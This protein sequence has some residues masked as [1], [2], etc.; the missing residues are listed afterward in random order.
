VSKY[1]EQYERM[2]RLYDRFKENSFRLPAEVSSGQSLKDDGLVFFLF[3]LH[4]RD[5]IVNDDELP[6]TVRDAA[7]PYVK[8]SRVL[9]LCHD[10][11]IGAKH[12]TVRSPL[13]PGE[14][15]RLNPIRTIEPRSAEM[16][17]GDDDDD[18]SLPPGTPVHVLGFRLELETDGGVVG[19][20]LFASDC[21]KEWDDFFKLHRLS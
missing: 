11:A 9:S 8:A 14:N 10:I 18:N 17:Y 5:W 12:L 7:F 21:L 20:L 6:Q 4:L 2:K 15:S 1:R 3:C 19:A 16:F 13:A